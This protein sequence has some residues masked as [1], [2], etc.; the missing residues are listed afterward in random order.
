M[1][2]VLSSVGDDFFDP[3][4]PF[5]PDDFVAGV[6]MVSLSSV[7]SV[8]PPEEDDDGEP[9]LP[10]LLL[11]LPLPLSLLLSLLE[12]E[13]EL[14]DDDDDVDEDD[15]RLV[16]DSSLAGE[17]PADVGGDMLSDDDP[18]DGVSC[19][20]RSRSVVKMRKMMLM[21]FV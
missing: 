20:Q 19:Q 10:P 14:G 8:P 9:L 16:A 3:P 2:L 5:F 7:S 18:S 17:L 1:L 13:P 21:Y 12:P 15:V 4:G 11:T 6:S